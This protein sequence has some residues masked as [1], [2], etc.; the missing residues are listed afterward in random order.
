MLVHFEQL[1]EKL[2]NREAKLNEIEIEIEE[3]RSQLPPLERKLSRFESEGNVKEAVAVGR[4]IESI[5]I[6][7][8]TLQGMR[9][10]ITEAQILSKEEIEQ[11]WKDDLPEI[12]KEAL[13]AE[14]RLKVA[15]EA[16]TEA[17]KSYVGAMM[18]LDLLRLDWESLA[19]IS[20]NGSM[21]VA[22]L[23]PHN[24]IAKYL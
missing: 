17:K 2:N 6:D 4:Q 12:G 21:K 11:A 19:R 9:S 15:H 13:Q 7:I 8:R 3:Y 20:G 10:K 24:Q 1:K 22:F 18:R 5:Q 14:A 23:E 16:Y